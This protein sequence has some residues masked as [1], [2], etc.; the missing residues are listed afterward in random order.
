M[1]R[2]RASGWRRIRSISV[3]LPTRM[4]ACGPPSSLSP[5]KQTTSAPSRSV[6]GTVGSP[7]KGYSPASSSA[8]LPKSTTSGIS[9]LFA[10]DASSPTDADAVNPTTRKLLVCTFKSAATSPSAQAAS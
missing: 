3:A 2:A 7:G 8:P 1:R 10:R 4:P 6:C 5:E 9:R